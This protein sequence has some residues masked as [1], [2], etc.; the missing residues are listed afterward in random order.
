MSKIA[1]L[2]PDLLSQNMRRV[3]TDSEQITNMVSLLDIN[4][5]TENYDDS[6]EIIEQLEATLQQLDTDLS[7]ITSELD[8]IIG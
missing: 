2:F 6:Q 5:A 7:A 8:L 1:R 4:I 3:V